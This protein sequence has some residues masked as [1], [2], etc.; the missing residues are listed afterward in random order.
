MSELTTSQAVRAFDV[1]P[2]ILNR[3]ILMGR[4]NARKNSDGRWLIERKSL[5]S[6]SRSR[7]RRAPKPTRST[8]PAESG[9][10]SP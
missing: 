8:T 10:T 2:N 3:L 6:W 5:E 9:H 4:L 1:H 7:V